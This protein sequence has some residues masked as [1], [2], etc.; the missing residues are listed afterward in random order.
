MKILKSEL[1]QII[2]EVTQGEMEFAELEAARQNFIENRGDD[3]AI[4]DL[5]V[6]VE[7]LVEPLMNLSLIH[8]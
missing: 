4:D 3:R 7:R 1:Q 6:M 8:I 5:L 2:K